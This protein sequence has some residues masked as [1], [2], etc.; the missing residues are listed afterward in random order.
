MMSNG[1]VLYDNARYALAEASRVD[2]VKGIRDKAVAMQVYAA[3]AKDTRLVEDATDIRMRAEIRAGELLAEQPK[4]KGTRGQF[5]GRDS[6][7]GTKLEPPENRA[8]TKLSDL[9]ITKKQSSDWQRLAALPEAEREDKIAAAKQK[10]AKATV[11]TKAPAAPKPAYRVEQE[12]GCTVKDLLTLVKQGRKFGTI[13]ADPPWVYDNQA[14]RAATGNHYDGLTVA[15][16]CALPIGELALPDAHLH[17]WTTNAFLFECPKIFDAWGFEFKSSF[18]WVKSQIGIGNYWRNSHEF[19][20]TAIRGDAKRFRDKGL[21]SW[22]ECSR[23][24]HSS[25][26]EQVRS[27]IQRASP[28]PYLELFGRRSAPGWVVWGDQIERTV[29]DTTAGELVA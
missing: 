2:E 13:Y 15:E 16:L 21:R 29:F 24:A 7:G 25:K 11:A 5:G 10:A 4:N 18:I 26:P 23:G 20:L 22:L 27:F 1:L 6:S 9:G 14:T 12:A 19:L 17:L 3:Q 28:M 8:P